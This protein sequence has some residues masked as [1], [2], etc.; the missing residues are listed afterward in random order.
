MDGSRCRSM[1]SGRNQGEQSVATGP[2]P[3]REEAEQDVLGRIGNILGNNIDRSSSGV[4][5]Y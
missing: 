4:K 1:R 3:S 5:N 2:F